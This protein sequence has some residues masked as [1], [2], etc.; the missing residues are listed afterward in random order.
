MAMEVETQTQ[1]NGSLTSNR[2]KDAASNDP[3]ENLW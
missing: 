2:R 3:K 1:V